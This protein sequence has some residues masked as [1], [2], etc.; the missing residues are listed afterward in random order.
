MTPLQKWM[1]K[2]LTKNEQKIFKKLNTPIKVQNYLSSLPINFEETGESLMSPRRLIKAKKAHC[3]EAAMFA[4]AALAY[5]GQK[6]LLL[7]FQSRPDDQDHVIAIFKQNN[8]WGAI[9]KTNHSILRW[10]DPVYKSVRE[11]AMSYFHEYLMDSGMKSLRAFSKPFNLSKYKPE[12]WVTTEKNLW[13]L[14]DEL[15]ES[16]HETIALPS[17]LKNLRRA[18]KIELKAM[19]LLE[20][21]K[22]KK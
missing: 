11:L 15:D 2:N 20:W 16:S 17:V 1:R 9:S 21:Q 4:A 13:W 8:R 22:K 7:D 3:M 18:D 6:P 10:R 14:A 19:K 12:R 5:H